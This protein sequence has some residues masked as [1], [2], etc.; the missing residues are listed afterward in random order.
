MVW[1]EAVETELGKQETIQAE[2]AVWTEAVETEPGRQE[3][4]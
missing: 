2:G 3:T 4:V 1:I